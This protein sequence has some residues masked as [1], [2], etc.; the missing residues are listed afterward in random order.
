LSFE[1][2]SADAPVAESAASA[3]AQWNLL[4]IVWSPVVNT[5]GQEIADLVNH[6]SSAFPF[7]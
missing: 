1:A 2:S 3:T 7:S 4:I 6:Q 5:K